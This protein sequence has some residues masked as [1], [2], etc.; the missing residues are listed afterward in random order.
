MTMGGIVADFAAIR[1]ARHPRPVH[2][3][4][5]VGALRGR[6]IADEI[7]AHGYFDNNSHRLSDEAIPDWGRVHDYFHEFVFIE[8]S[9]GRITIIVAAND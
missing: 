5:P 2:E 4:E 1:Q 3:A 8:R 6:S 9:V 7:A